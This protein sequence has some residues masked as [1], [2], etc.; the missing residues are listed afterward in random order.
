MDLIQRNQ[1]DRPEQLLLSLLLHRINSRYTET[2]IES[3]SK[4]Y[5]VLKVQSR[6]CKDDDLETLYEVAPATNDCKKE[7]YYFVSTKQTYI[8]IAVDKDD[9]DAY[10]R[11]YNYKIETT[12]KL[13]DLSQQLFEAILRFDFTTNHNLLAW[14]HHEFVSATGAP[15]NLEVVISIVTDF[16]DLY[17][18]MNLGTYYVQSRSINLHKTIYEIKDAVDAIFPKCI[19]WHIDINKKIETSIDTRRLQHFFT[20]FSRFILTAVNANY[21]LDRK[22]RRLKYCIDFN[23]V[24]QE[25]SLT[26]KI[27]YNEAND[28]VSSVLRNI[29][30]IL[31]MKRHHSNSFSSF[32]GLYIACHFLNYYKSD[33]QILPDGLQIQLPIKTLDSNLPFIMIL[34][35]LSKT[36]HQLLASSTSMFLDNDIHRLIQIIDNSKSLDTIDTYYA[37]NPSNL[38]VVYNSNMVNENKYSNTHLIPFN[39]GDSI[40]L[41]FEQ[42][43]KVLRR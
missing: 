17:N 27:I 29:D 30:Y 31:S 24:D 32:I 1:D 43:A 36:Q 4:L 3:I 41:L 21:Q 14:L 25:A 9:D 5:F 35:N 39:E 16:V 33:L 8:N 23:T 13:N 18:V 34:H 38:I 7:T 37:M 26:V 22:V 28:L 40:Q 10:S 2:I 12:I 20:S 6:L 15:S 42:L 19:M 11:F